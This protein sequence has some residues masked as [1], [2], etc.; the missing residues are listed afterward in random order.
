V[1]T[2]IPKF[3]E[4]LGRKRPKEAVGPEKS[5]KKNKREV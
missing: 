1:Q 4:F 2:E 5:K 3:D